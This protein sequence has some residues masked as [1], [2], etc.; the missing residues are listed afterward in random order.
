[1]ED[2]VGTIKELI[3]EGKV[4]HFGMSEANASSVRNAHANAR[5]NKIAAADPRRRFIVARRDAAKNS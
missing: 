4:R 2:A 5:R 3:S 1:V